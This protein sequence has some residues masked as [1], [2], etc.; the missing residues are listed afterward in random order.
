M[1]ELPAVWSE[2]GSILDEASGLAEF[3]ADRLVRLI[4]VV[5]MPA[6]R[7]PTYRAVAERL[8]DFVAKR[9]SDAQGALILLR[10]ALGLDD[11]ERC[12]RIRLLGRA[13]VRLAKREH[14][15]QLIEAHQHLAIAYRGADL[16]WAA[17]SSIL[18]AAAGLAAEGEESSE[19]PV[20]FVPTVKIWA[21]IALQLRLVPE[22]LLAVRLLRMSS[23]TLPLD[24][25]SKA[26]V[27]EGLQELDIAFGSN[28]LNMADDELRALSSLPDELGTAGMQMSRIALLYALGYED[29][30][31]GDGSIPEEVAEGGAGEFFALMKAQ[32]VSRQLFGRLILNA[33][34]GQVIETCICGLTVE[35][36]APGDDAGTVTAQA[37]VAAFEAMLATMIEDGVGPHTE[38][39]RVDIVETEEDEPSVRTDPKSMRS[40]VAWPRSLP[41]SDF[42]R[43]PDIGAF[44]MQVVG[45]AMAA[46]FVLPRLKEAM[47]R[48]IAKGS[49]HDRVSS[50]LAS[51][52][53]VHRIAGR[54]V[55]RLDG[56]AKDYPMRDRPAVPDM[57][58][59]AGGG[60]DEDDPKGPKV[61][62]GRATVDRHR[63]VKVQS[64]IDVHSW[65]EARWK[66]ILYASYGEDVPPILALAFTNAAGARR[67]FERWRERF[68][69]KD[70]DHDINMSIIRNLPDHPASHYAVQITSR[71]PND[72]SWERGVL[73]QTV[74]RVHV[75]EPADD[76]N[77]QTFLAKRRAAGCFMLAPAV[78]SAGQPEIL[79]D[80][81][82]LKRDVTVVDAADV[83]EHDIE[84]IAL[85]MIA[86]RADV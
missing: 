33:P 2:L 42:S 32:P 64:V 26:R 5:A 61:G 3:D 65:D 67:I 45:E 24:D 27:A 4:E 50:V 22:L 36:A 82:I 78:L 56:A 14:A 79:T 66:G 81:V 6:G 84:H 58:L 9:T 30:L 48:L 80:L 44:L 12:E 53:A 31:R 7:D 10:Q 25:D 41:V 8:A 55:I 16:L 54:P 72:G 34:T 17:R 11:D 23:G 28:I 1:D 73:Y 49:A 57:E 39:F 35:V 19:L 69:T 75:M 15:E 52:S 20:G 38:R 21:W 71:R 46:T 60:D 83:A 77:L 76:T 85:E 51:L 37:V 40:L 13:A 18:M 62:D 63:G 68:G 29:T 59:P 43:Q 74:N 70:V 47:E 86:T